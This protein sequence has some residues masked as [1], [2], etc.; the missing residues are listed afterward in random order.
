[1]NCLQGEVKF[2]TGGNSNVDLLVR[3]RK[4]I[5]CD[6]ETD[7]NCITCRSPDERR[8]VQAAAFVGAVQHLHILRPVE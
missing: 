4:L 1:M 5:R 8:C 2:L 3:A 7:G 6:S